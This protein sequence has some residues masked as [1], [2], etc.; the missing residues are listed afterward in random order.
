MK[1][2]QKAVFALILAN[3]IWGAAAPIF[4]WSLESTPPFTLAVLRFGIASL[5]FLPLAKRHSFSIK[6]KHILLLIIMSFLGVSLH[7]S[8]FF[9]GLGYTDSINAPIIASSGPLFIILF[10]FLFLKDKI[11]KRTMIGAFIG[12]L[13]VL[14][15]IVLPAVEKGLDGSIVGNVFFVIAMLAGVI[16]ALLLKKLMNGYHPFTIA[17]WTFLIGTIGFLPMFFDEIQ[18][19][20]F[21]PIINTQVIVGILFGAL[22]SSS[23]A[24]ALQ[25]WALQKMSVEDVGLFAYVDPVIAVLIA[26]PLL[27][28]Q[29]TSVFFA[30]SFFVFFGIY[31][32]EG[33]IHWHPIHR[34]FK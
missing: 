3:F 32:A 15:I 7:I 8:F 29:P 23:L 13:G 2:T 14:A 31:I 1:N 16:Y 10:G 17:F 20:G 34:L 4:K 26:A 12:L 30:G 19:V 27:G 22:L 18:R 9:L 33:R 25:M 21:L 28:E 5:I 11:K 24:Y 6:S